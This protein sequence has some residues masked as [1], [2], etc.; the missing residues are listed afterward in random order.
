[1]DRILHRDLNLFW[2]GCPCEHNRKTSFESQI[3]KQVVA[4]QVARHRDFRVT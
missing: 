4:Q 2:Q 1:M 3:L